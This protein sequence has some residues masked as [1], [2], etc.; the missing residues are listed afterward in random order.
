MKRYSLMTAVLALML[1]GALALTGCPKTTGDDDPDTS[2]VP[3]I[4][5]VPVSDPVDLTVPVVDKTAL[6]TA[7]TA[8]AAAGKDGTANTLYWVPTATLTA[9]ETA[10]TEA[11]TV[12]ANANADQAAVD[13]AK[14]TLEGA[15]TAFTGQKSA[16]ETN[17][18][19]VLGAIKTAYNSGTGW[20]GYPADPTPVTIIVSGIITDTSTAPANGWLDI[21]VTDTYP[22]IT[23]QGT[24]ATGGGTLDATTA[25]PRKRVLNINNGHKV[26]LGANLTLTGGSSTSA[27]GVQIGGASTFTMTDGTISGNSTTSSMGGG[28]YLGGSS[29]TF[30]MTG[31]TI[32]GN[33]AK[34]SGGGVFVTSSATFKMDNGTISGNGATQTYGGGVMIGSGTF[35]MND[36]TISGNTAKTTGGGVQVGNDATFTKNGGIIKGGGSGTAPDN[37]ATDGDASGNKGH[38]V[39]WAQTGAL[40]KAD[41]DVEGDLKTS[42]ATAGWTAFT[43]P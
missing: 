6:Q 26:T 30:T 15:T 29:T 1:A 37:T 36:G 43:L 39:Y 23:L 17:P 5:T 35:T 33:T 18:V 20:P 32:S 34:T 40:R 42:D 2:T 25:S 11:Q 24:G 14:T 4:P 13:S 9:F 8:A 19:T 31:G 38:A 21:S 22:P 3:T 10:I 41:D 27:G 28:V 7:L 12:N 16:A